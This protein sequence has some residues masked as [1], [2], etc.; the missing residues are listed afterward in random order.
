MLKKIVNKNKGGENS[1]AN[2][3]ETVNGARQEN[4]IIRCGSH[5]SSC[6]RWNCLCTSKKKERE[7]NEKR[8]LTLHF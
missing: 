3:K 2:K 5:S 4:G 7:N 1:K 8:L 6:Y